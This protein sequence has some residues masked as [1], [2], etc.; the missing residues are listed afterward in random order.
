MWLWPPW[1][2]RGAGKE[3]SHLELIV[4]IAAMLDKGGKAHISE[5]DI[6]RG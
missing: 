3:L 1:P 4:W 2:A 5:R 6:G